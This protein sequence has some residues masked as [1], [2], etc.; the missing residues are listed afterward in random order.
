MRSKYAAILS[1]VA[2]V[3]LV[4]IVYSVNRTNN[5]DP[6]TPRIRAFYRPYVRNMNQYYDHTINNYGL[7]FIMN[8]LRKWNIY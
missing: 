2:I 4:W 8:K 1:I 5:I 3:L 6:F 7:Q